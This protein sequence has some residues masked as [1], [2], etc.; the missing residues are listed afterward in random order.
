MASLLNLDLVFSWA[1]VIKRRSK[2]GGRM[3]RVTRVIVE[4]LESYYEKKQNKRRLFR[5]SKTC[6]GLMIIIQDKGRPSWFCTYSSN[7]VEW[8]KQPQTHHTRS[9]TGHFMVHRA[10]HKETQRDTKS[11][12]YSYSS[13]CKLVDDNGTK[14]GFADTDHLN[15]WG[16]RPFN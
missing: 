7:Q 9:L 3:G 2:K 11:F 13:K 4:L 15:F 12:E 10:A 14:C 8:L 16:E 6:M 5:V 1:T